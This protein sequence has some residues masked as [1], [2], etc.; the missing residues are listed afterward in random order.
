MKEGFY[1]LKPEVATSLGEQTKGDFSVHP[2]RIQ[3]LHCVLEGWLGDDLLAMFPCFLVTDELGA[4]LTR[5]DLTGFRL[6]PLQLTVSTQFLEINPNR[7]IPKLNWLRV[8]GHIGRHDFASADSHSLYVSHNGLELL[9]RYRL[10]HCSIA[11]VI[12][13]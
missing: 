4:G 10:M 13:E 1:I 3:W 12:D 7:R 2:P 5:S 11:R 6:E 8:G 9:R